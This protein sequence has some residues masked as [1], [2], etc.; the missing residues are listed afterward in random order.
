MVKWAGTAARGPLLECFNYFALY[1]IKPESWA[2]AQVVAIFKKGKA[3]LPQNYRPISFLNCLYKIYA[4]MV[5]VRL[6]DE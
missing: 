3:S 4:R 2:E 5:A 6:L 1:D